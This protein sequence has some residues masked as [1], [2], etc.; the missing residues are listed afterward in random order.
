MTGLIIGKQLKEFTAA[1]S[2]LILFG[3]M[4]VIC[5]VIAPL[6]SAMY[7]TMFGVMFSLVFIAQ[8]SP[9]LFV[10][11]KGNHTLETLVT[12]PVN[13]RKIIYG[14]VLACFLIS[15]GLFLCAT[16][17]GM[18]VSYIA[19]KTTVFT[20]QQALEYIL[21]MPVTFLLFS[22]QATYFSLKSNDSSSCALVLTFVAIL[23][24]L[25]AIVV[26]IFILE[27]VDSMVKIWF[28]SLRL[29]VFSI[30]CIYLALAVIVYAVLRGLFGRYYDKTKIFSLL[31]N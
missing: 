6:F 22:Y 18:L 10:D 12:L 11:E 1:K 30:A 9:E 31:R 29:N 28:L 3:A 26:L 15:L 21:L 25:P 8:I 4:I 19:H 16:G 13:I 17:L 20:W 14:K 7:F 27:Q 5:G 2:N 23:Y 24:S